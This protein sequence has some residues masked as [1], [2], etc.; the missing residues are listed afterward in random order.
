MK[1]KKIG[2]IL[3]I[4]FLVILGMFGI[5]ALYETFFTENPSPYSV[6]FSVLILV[7]IIGFFILI[8]LERIANTFPQN[9]TLK[10]IQQRGE[11]IWSA[12]LDALTNT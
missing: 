8:L 9:K 7:T 11:K 4:T 2:N 3:G 10:K 1:N 5:Y 12:I 6:I